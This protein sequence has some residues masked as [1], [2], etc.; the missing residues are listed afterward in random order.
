[1]TESNETN[2]DEPENDP[3]LDIAQ[4]DPALARHLRGSL[5]VLRDRAEN[6]EFR[7]TVDEVLAGR[8]DLREAIS[9]PAFTSVLNP[10]VQRFAEQYEE[11]SEDEREQL[12][13]QGE[14]QLAEER[15]RIAQERGR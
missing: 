11:L 9:S 8:A 13:A 3:L 15:E 2:P 12:A 14:Q 7:Q 4:G 10:L 1:M 5:Q 6:D